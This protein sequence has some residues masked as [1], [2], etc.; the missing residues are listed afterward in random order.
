MVL[1]FL[2]SLP[3]SK[4]DLVS[5]IPH[6]RPIILKMDIVQEESPTPHDGEYVAASLKLG[7]TGRI[8][9]GVSGNLFCVSRAT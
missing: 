5:G 9:Y 1:C 6:L 7:E 2:Y 8:P 3:A 4:P